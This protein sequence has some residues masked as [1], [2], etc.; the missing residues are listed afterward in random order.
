MYTWTA[1]YEPD[2]AA[3]YEADSHETAAQTCPGACL[4][5]WHRACPDCRHCHPYLLLLHVLPAV[6]QEMRCQPKF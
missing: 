4:D 2:H 1:Y 3:F 6:V 5:R